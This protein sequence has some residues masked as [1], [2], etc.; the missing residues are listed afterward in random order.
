MNILTRTKEKSKRSL[1]QQLNADEVAMIRCRQ[2]LKI[3]AR[4]ESVAPT[5][6]IGAAKAY[7][8]GKCSESRNIFIAEKL[9]NKDGKFYKGVGN[10]FACNE[11]LC[12]NCAAKKSKESR[13]K[14][15]KAVNKLN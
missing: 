12:T 9:Q 1:K 3:A 11:R 2:G 5:N 6:S 13:I 15:R 4:L 7:R 14:A 8:I 10:R